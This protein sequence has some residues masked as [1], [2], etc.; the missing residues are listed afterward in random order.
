MIPRSEH[1]KPQFMR[2][3]WL[4]LNG[5]WAFEIDQSRSGEYRNLHA[6]DAQLSGEILVPFCPES[7]LSGVGHKDFINGVWYQKKVTL[8]EEQCAGTVFLHFGAVDYEATV[9]VNGKKAGSHK[10]GYVSFKFDITALVNP[11]ENVIT[12]NAI[13]DSRQRLIPSG[14]QSERPY[15]YGCFYTRTTGIWQTVWLEFAPKAYIKSIRYETNPNQGILLLTAQLE[16]CGDFRAKASYE[17]KDMGCASAPNARG[18][19]NLSLKVDEIHLWEVGQGRLYDLE[20]TFG[21]DTVH[22][23]FGLRSIQLDGMKFLLNGKSVFQRLILDQGFYPDGIYTAPSDA[24]LEKDITMSMDMGFNGARPHEKIFEERYFYHCDRH[25]YLVWGEYPNWGLDHS[26]PNSVFS[27]LPEWL[28]EVERDRNH[29]SIIGWCPFNETWPVEHRPQVNDVLRMVY[30]ATKAAD[31]GRPV[32]D[33]S[34]GFHVVTDI[35]DVHD[36]DQN[37][38]TFKAN[39]DRFMTEDFLYDWLKD[40]YGMQQY[41]GGPAFVSEYGG[42]RWAEGE[43]DETGVGSWGYGKDVEGLEDFK[44]R[45]KGLTDALLDNDKMLGLCYTQLT[46]VEQEQNGLYTYDRQA[47]FDPEWVKSVMSR[48]AAIED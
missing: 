23:Y 34:G 31:P 17:G 19:L 25:G 43:K 11:G 1:P 9:Y 2:D 36:Y 40:K 39:Y 15:S 44:R 35:Y 12:L 6:A 8:T 4:N 48:K 14:K 41:A 33:V 42:I 18:E 24:A 16:G 21:E 30:L 7:K 10:G 20:L 37:P 32:I 45:F 27:I 22:S 3:S 28:E 46:D 47:K 5:T 13:D 38:E 29:P 26:N